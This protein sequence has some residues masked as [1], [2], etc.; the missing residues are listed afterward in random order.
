MKLIQLFTGF[1]AIAIASAASCQ[2]L[3]VRKEMNGMH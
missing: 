3:T 1:T 2:K